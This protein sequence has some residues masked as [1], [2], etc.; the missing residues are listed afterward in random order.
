MGNEQ[1]KANAQRYGQDGK[2]QGD[3]QRFAKQ[4]I[5]QRQFAVVLQPHIL[6]RIDQVVLCEAQR[7]THH[8]R[9]QLE[10]QNAQYKGQHKEKPQALVLV[11]GG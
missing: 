3:P 9:K 1:R 10:Q 5:V 4:G 7:K 8:E 11:H 6:R 2:Q